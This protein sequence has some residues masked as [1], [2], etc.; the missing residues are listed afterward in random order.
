MND[1]LNQVLLM[2][3][4]LVQEIIPRQVDGAKVEVRINVLGVVGAYTIPIEILIRD[5]MRLAPSSAVALQVMNEETQAT[6]DDKEAYLESVKQA[7]A[8]LIE[9]LYV[10]F[11]K[12]VKLAYEV[13]PVDVLIPAI[14]GGARHES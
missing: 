10:Q 3:R 7:A 8:C 11:T 5:D 1:T 13:D 4:D 6:L 14:D 2:M 12:N 9:Q